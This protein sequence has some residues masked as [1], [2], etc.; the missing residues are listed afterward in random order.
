MID[1]NIAKY[2]M[3][4]GDRL[5][6]IIHKHYGLEPAQLSGALN[7]ILDHNPH[8]AGVKQP[9]KM[10]LKPLIIELPPLP[11]FEQVQE[12]NLWS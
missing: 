1:A 7:F 8:L 5:D 12:V 6:L 4:D 9:F 2:M 10:G 11:V 3:V